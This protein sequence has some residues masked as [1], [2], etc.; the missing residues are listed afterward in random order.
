M[1][2]FLTEACRTEQWGKPG[3]NKARHE[4]ASAT[5]AEPYASSVQS[6]SLETGSPGACSLPSAARAFL[7]RLLELRLVN[8]C[9]I[10]EFLKQASGSFS[11]WSNPEALG[12]ALVGAS[13][14]TPYQLDRVLAGTTHGL[15]LGNHRVLNRLGAGAMGVVF[16][17]EHILMR[18]QVA[19][20]VLPV[21][22]DCPPVLWERFCCEMQGLAALHHPHIVLAFDAG[23]VA[24]MDR[25]MPSLLYLVMELVPGGDLDQY[26]RDHGPVDIAQ[27]CEW[28]RQAACG[29]QEAH[30]HHLI[31]RD[32]K[33]SNL[34][35]TAQ[36][37]VK[38]TDFGLVRQFSSRLTSP[39]ALLGTLD[40]MAPEQSCDPSLV[41]G[42]ADIYGL[43]ATLLWLLTGELPYG[44]ASSLGQAMRALQSG[45]PRRLRSLRPDAPAELDALLDRMLR[46]DPSERPASPLSVMNEL[47]PFAT[48]S[49]ARMSDWPSETGR[50][51]ESTSPGAPEM[52]PT[53]TPALCQAPPQMRVLMVDDEPNVRQLAR[54]TLESLGLACTD[55]ADAT[56]ALGLLEHT[57][58]DLVL[59]DLNLPDMDG[60]EL[61]QRLRQPPVR[62]NLKIIVVSG[63]G[64][65]N[66]LCEALPRGADDYIVKPFGVR[67]LQARV[68]HALRLKEA[69]D[70]TEVRARQ[71]ALSHRQLEHS[72][73]ARTS[74]VRQAEDALLFAMAKMAESKDGE[75]SG[76]LRRLQR[77]TRCL[78]ERVA[79]EPSWEG[80]INSAFLE[81]LERCMPLHDIGKIGVPEHI[82]LKPGQLTETERSLMETH[83]LIGDRILE[84]L[85]QEY[86][87]SLV[88]LRM[89]SAIVRHHHERYDGT[90]YPDRLAGDAIPAAARLA[91]VADVYDA[92]R[93]PR[94][95]KPPLDHTEAARILLHGSAGQF[96]PAVLQAFAARQQQ[97]DRIYRD[98]RT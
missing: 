37:Q 52:F 21:D 44:P 86:G 43:G 32:V 11:E 34:L 85:G 66:Q 91:A 40:Y 79:E 74:D 2:R 20:K 16:L 87:A 67:Q 25:C 69:Q 80:V 38:V 60:Y 88:F 57:P 39:D 93:R 68:E 50:Q 9:S 47:L 15:V 18:R 31:H 45:Q 8:P 96:D 81:Q 51:E 6:G 3:M 54:T 72:L 78:A 13:L 49:V 19:I 36:K 5:S 90:G 24:E 75:N 26:V 98:I 29:L 33:P 27:A 94:F 10:E 48:R 35:L 84:A 17:A 58:Y 41:D 76:H 23:H 70:Q 89:A 82:L 14:L 77:Y 73:A 71:L 97:F 62:S 4:V 12:N 65:Q 22:E 46:R 28:V 63:R 64:D 61:C 30:D 42:R 1:F 92:L 7:D 53:S 55:A 59:L 56:T 95:H 83:T